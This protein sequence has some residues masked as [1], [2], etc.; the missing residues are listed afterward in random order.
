MKILGIILF[1]L[2][3]YV[4]APAQTLEELY[5][6]KQYFDLQDAVNQQT[7]ASANYLFYKAVVAN[8]F[9]DPKRSTELLL[10]FLKK[11]RAA[12]RTA[13][14]AYELL[15]DN[16]V[17]TH[18]YVKAA[19]TYKMLLEKFADSL[20]SAAR[21]SYA[22]L[23]GL[24][25]ALRHEPA[26][27]VSMK[28]ETVIQGTRDKAR[29]LNIAVEASGQKMDFIFDT[30]AGLSTMTV[31]TAQKLGLKIIE[32][33]VSVGSSTDINVKSK[34][35]VAPEVRIGNIVVRNV[36]FLVME[37][38]TLYVAPISYQI[39]AIIGFPVIKGLGRVTIG[40]N[41]ELRFSTSKDATKAGPNMAL[42]GLKPLV[43][44]SYN[45]KRVIFAF[46]TGAT[47][48]TFYPSFYSGS[49]EPARAAATEYTLRS[50]GAGGIQMNAG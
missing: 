6:A 31:S 37:D 28:G 29:L 36:V 2:L 19:D 35:A 33:D 7:Q 41:D 38:K 25:G 43:A 22:N 44:A 11:D 5:K 4:A 39:N 32:S 16:Y 40:R 12:G 18:Q 26:Q 24:W 10:K 14:E 46:D 30:G 15:A 1:A 42:E 20:E 48:T 49:S 47:R 34:L 17:K 9:N 13:R 27:T 8:S 23:G 3:F 50:G 21:E 45:N